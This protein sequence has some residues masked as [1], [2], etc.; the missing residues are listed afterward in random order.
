MFYSIFLTI[1]T[2]KL[3]FALSFLA[4]LMLNLESDTTLIRNTST[5][6]FHHSHAV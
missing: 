2:I 6:E 5:V 4:A 1:P 3:D